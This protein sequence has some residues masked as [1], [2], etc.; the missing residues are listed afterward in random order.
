AGVRS[1]GSGCLLSTF[2]FVPWSSRLNW[3]KDEEWQV[4]VPCLDPPLDS[5]SSW[6]VCAADTVQRK[7]TLE[8]LFVHLLSLE[9]MLRVKFQGSCACCRTGERSS[10]SCSLCAGF[11]PWLRFFGTPGS[12]SGSVSASGW[13]QKSPCQLNY[14]E[15]K[16]KEDQILDWDSSGPCQA[17]QFL[18]ITCLH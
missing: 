15:R 7:E 12:V 13:I 11:P 8:F 5:R 10:G 3:I 6:W 9:E 1:S 17:P 4:G 16:G 2:P 14:S 18:W